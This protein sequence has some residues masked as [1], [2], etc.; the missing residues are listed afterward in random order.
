MSLDSLIASS[1]KQIQNT[2]RIL[3]DCLV[4]LI[5]LPNKLRKIANLVRTSWQVEHMGHAVKLRKY[6]RLLK[7][8]NQQHRT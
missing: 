4:A 1:H 6:L 8:S 5:F 3:L 2:K 7:H